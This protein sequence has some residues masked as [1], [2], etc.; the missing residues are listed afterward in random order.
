[1]AIV[2]AYSIK[3]YKRSHS[4]FESEGCMFGNLEVQ[5]LYTT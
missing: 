4:A 1:V 5:V 3:S 2:N